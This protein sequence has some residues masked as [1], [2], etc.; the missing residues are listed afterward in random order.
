MNAWIFQDA[1]Q[2]AKLGDKCPWSV[3][4]YDPEGRRKSKSIGAKSRAETFARKTEGELAAGIYEGHS[5]KRWSDF[6][7]EY[8]AR[9][10]TGSAATTCEQTRFAL[11]HFN[12]VIN[13]VRV[14]AIS[15][16]TFAEYV[17][18]RKAESARPGG[19]LV[20]PATVN[21]EL[22]HLRAMVRKAHRWGYLPRVPEIEFLREPGKLATYVTPEHFA[23]MYEGCD[24]M[25]WPNGG[26]YTAG[27]WWRALLV[28]AYMTGWRIGSLM[29]LRWEDVDL[30]TATS[31]SRAEDN[32]GRRDQR[33]PLHSLVVEHLL[34]L[35]SFWPVVFTWDHS[36]RRLFDELHKLQGAAGVRPEG[37]KAHYGFHDFR[38]AFATL[39]AATLTPDALQALMQH[40]DYQTTQ[41]YI[42]MARQLNPA[43]QNLYVPT[44][45]RI[46]ARE[47]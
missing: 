12:R 22:R 14:S 16:R 26:P 32:K 46:A 40:K 47:A 36:H 8:F 44:L 20:S 21:K 24:S 33:I 39:N 17:A 18:V 6:C 37:T 29:A 3:G 19:P 23:K 27:D 34:K 25:R 7:D 43:V 5:R 30:E 42:N 35:K 41:R 11:A 1:K 2:K 13:P 10:T 4:W 31:V 45:P 28:M 9:G 38:R 15:S